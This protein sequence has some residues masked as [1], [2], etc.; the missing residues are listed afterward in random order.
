VVHQALVR[1][2]LDFTPGNSSTIVSHYPPSSS[3]RLYSSS[4]WDATLK[5][6]FVN[7]SDDTIAM[8]NTYIQLKVTLIDDG[9]PR[10]SPVPWFDDASGWWHDSLAA[11]DSNIPA[12]VVPYVNAMKRR[13]CSHSW[14]ASGVE[15]VPPPF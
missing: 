7:S 13:F 4:A 10:T 15:C 3:N 14:K 9:S 6:A 5:V 12:A 8:I 1:A 2:L 11:Y